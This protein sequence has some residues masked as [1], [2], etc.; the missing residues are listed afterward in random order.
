MR[1]GVYDRVGWQRGL[2][3]GHSGLNLDR[4]VS[5]LTGTGPWRENSPSLGSCPL[6]GDF[7]DSP[8]SRNRRKRRSTEI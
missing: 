5:S 2:V 4:T 6:S 1:V 8:Y 3:G 7:K